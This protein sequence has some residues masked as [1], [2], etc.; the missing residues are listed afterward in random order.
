MAE[1]DYLKT[2]RGLLA[3]SESLGDT[4]EGRMFM[5]KALELM[6]KHGIDE[7]LAFKANPGTDKMIN[8]KIPFAGKFSKAKLRLYGAIVKA[9]RGTPIIIDS[10]A[11][12]L[13]VFIYQ[14]DFEK[15]EILYTLLLQQGI[16]DLNRA[17]MPYWETSR[18]SFSAA[19]WDGFV[20]EIARRLEEAN[21]V[22]AKD[23]APGT[24]LVL[25]NRKDATNTAMHHEY[26]QTRTQYRKLAN[27]DAGY[28]AGKEAGSRANLHQSGQVKHFHQKELT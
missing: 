2:V 25:V 23:S 24:A 18:K 19:F 4:P 7:A 28:S 12:L 13:H 26:P 16:S 27:S 15:V 20:V 5:A 8:K 10:K 11:N 21:K 9:Y 22:V 17:E 6:A 3:K 1:K 14:S